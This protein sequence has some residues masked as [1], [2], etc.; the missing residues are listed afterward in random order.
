MIKELYFK[1]STNVKNLIG[2]DLVTDEITAVFELVKNSYDADATEVLVEFVGLDSNHPKL[3]IKDNGHGMDLNDIENKWMVIGT[4]S[5]QNKKESEKFKRPLNGDKGIGR[6]SA[7]RLGQQ[8]FL[9]SQKEN[10]SERINILF[11][12]K[13]FEDNY[14]HLEEIKFPLETEQDNKGNN[15]VTLEIS[16]L[17]D[18]WNQKM[19]DKLEKSL[20]Q[21]KSPFKLED[22]F[23][24]KLHVPK[25]GYNYKNIE[26]YKLEDISSLWVKA[27]ISLENTDKINV[28]IMRDGV[29]Y[30]EEYPN[31]YSF[32]P[33]KSVVYFFDKGD[34]IRFRNRIG[35][36]V[37]DFGNI[38]MY[39]DSFKVH[40]Y[41]EP[42]NDW[43]DL[44]RRKTQGYA[45]FFG[46]RDI[47]GY[48]QV[49]KN[50]NPEIIPTTNRQ[51]I[52]DN[53]HS[54]ELREFLVK[55][56]LKNIEKYYF[57]K[58]DNESYKKSKKNIEEA[59]TELKKAAKDVK[60]YSPEAANIITKYTNL[61]QKSQ[62]DQNEYVKAQ[63]ELMN[64]YKRVASKELLMHQIVHQSLI[65]MEKIK[66]IS[67]SGV[68]NIERRILENDVGRIKRDYIKIDK[69]ITETKDYLKSVRDHL[70][71]KRNKKRYLLKEYIT[72]FIDSYKDELS[73]EGISINLTVPE[74]SSLFIDEND[75][76]TII[77]NFISNSIKA[78]K[79]I[80]K[81]DK[82]IEIKVLDNIDRVIL[83]FKDNGTGIPEHM[84]DRIFDPFFS[85]TDGFGMGLAIVDEIVKEYNGQLNLAMNNN[86]GAEFQIRFRK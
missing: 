61:V 55:F 79:N 18:E 67:L 26:P 49:F 28:T 39:R 12:W 13:D 14:N 7:D 58:P 15:G 59:V 45:R 21:L 11:D 80:T 42:F 10:S 20:K 6:F 84:K 46:S 27:N 9:S 35:Q 64:V 4:S 30:S 77:E 82:K 5:K 25:Y 52:I 22:N 60:E 37:V 40:P 51:G 3:I 78:L 44:D 57:K 65:R 17:R 1:A 54:Q 48:V 68:N 31:T 29:K 73:H 34:K 38:R 36:N 85:S 75:I 53:A 66:S 23:S 47:V 76:Q 69:F 81:E 83:I 86:D 41:G 24:I 8:L 56:P 32:G 33:V 50:H 19:I 2:K 43:L 71:R 70:M 72:E 16:H 74:N 62:K 63:T